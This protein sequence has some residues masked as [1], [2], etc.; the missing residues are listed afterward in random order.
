MLLKN[1]ATNRQQTVQRP[2]EGTNDFGLRPNIHSWGD[3]MV[4][5]GDDDDDDDWNHEKKVKNSFEEEKYFC[6]FS[7]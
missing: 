5:T 3:V 2:G 1:A 6:F 7:L 4:A